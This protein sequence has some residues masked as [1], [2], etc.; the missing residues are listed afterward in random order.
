MKGGPLHY[1]TELPGALK[2][3]EGRVRTLPGEAEGSFSLMT[4]LPL[5]TL[6]LL[7]V[8]DTHASLR[9]AQAERRA[10]RLGFRIP[11]LALTSLLPLA[12][13]SSLARFFFFLTRSESR[14]QKYSSKPVCS[15]FS[16]APWGFSRGNLTP[17][18]P[19][20]KD[21]KITDPQQSLKISV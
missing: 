9:H 10:H 7:I 8:K 6:T 16:L 18:S 13:A 3:R 14:G 15:G 2:L 5:P 21:V 19:V 1:H 20:P 12:M 17:C 11:S 4:S